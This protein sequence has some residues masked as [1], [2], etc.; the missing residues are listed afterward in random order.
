MV[1]AA[2]SLAAGALVLAILVPAGPDTTEAGIIQDFGLLET[3]TGS[4]GRVVI[5]TD[6]GRTV[7]VRAPD[8]HRCRVGDRVEVL[9]ETMIWGKASHLRRRGCAARR[10]IG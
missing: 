2:A 5:R 10:P 9:H 1:L 4:R 3:D 7:N 8:A 6:S